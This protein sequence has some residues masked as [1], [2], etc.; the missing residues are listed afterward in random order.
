MRL[1]YF[2]C[3]CLYVSNCNQG[4]IFIDL[5]LTKSCSGI[6]NP[7]GIQRKNDEFR[8]VVLSHLVLF[9]CLLFLVFILTL[10]MIDPQIE[11]CI[12]QRLSLAEKEHN[13]RILYAIESS[14]RAWGF[15]STNNDYEVRFVYAHPRDWYLSIDFENKRD[16]IECPLSDHVDLNGWDV[17][18]ALKLF[19]QSNPGMMEW[20]ASPIVYRNDWVFAPELKECTELYY[21]IERGLYHYRSMAMKHYRTHLQNIDTE[22]KGGRIDKYLYVLRAIFSVI[23]L[24]EYKVPAPVEFEK[25]RAVIHHYPELNDEIEHLLQLGEESQGA[26]LSSP[27]PVLASYIEQQLERLEQYSERPKWDQDEHDDAVFVKILNDLFIKLVA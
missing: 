8:F 6:N 12:Q 22:E 5:S 16:V 27:L 19:F 21:S 10:S 20:L 1:F 2:Y 4:V 25:L 24:E 17:R 9:K 15:E 23:W 14:S 11:T 13:V 26:I 3:C 18:K 7:Q